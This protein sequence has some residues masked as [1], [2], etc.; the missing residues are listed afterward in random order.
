MLNLAKI[1]KPWKEAGAL[2]AQLAPYGFWDGH[3]LLTKSGDLAVMLRAGCVDYESLDSAGQEYAVRRMESAMKGF[4]PGFHIYQYLFK[5]SRPDIPFTNYGDPIVDM[6]VGQ[7]R[8]YFAAKAD[9][10]YEIEIVYVLLL[11]GPPDGFSDCLRVQVVVLVGFHIR[12]HVLRRHQP[13]IV[14]LI[15]QGAS[16]AM[17]SPAS[18]HPDQHR[19]AR[20]RV[21]QELAPRKL[22]AE[23]NRAR[24]AESNEVKSSLTQVDAKR[25]D[26]HDAISC[27]PR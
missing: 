27:Q 5:R 23:H 7:R 26:L 22:F 3:T 16:E 11:E 25:C 24:G 4:D 10:L 2:N 19:L 14:A 12:L 18:F 17:G 1:V 15:P 20:G 8:D 9:R 6:A 13:G 21:K